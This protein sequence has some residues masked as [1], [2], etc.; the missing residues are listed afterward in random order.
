MKQLWRRFRRR[1]P[2]PAVPPPAVLPPVVLPPDSEQPFDEVQHWAP[3]LIGSVPVVAGLIALLVLL[4]L[5]IY[6]LRHRQLSDETSERAEACEPTDQHHA[7]QQRSSALGEEEGATQLRRRQPR[8]RDD[9]RVQVVQRDR[10]A[11]TRPDAVRPA[12]A[13]AVGAT[14]VEEEAEERRTKRARPQQRGQGEDAVV[15]LHRLRR[16]AAAT[17]LQ[18]AQRGRLA[19]Q[20]YDLAWRHA[21]RRTECRACSARAAA[22]APADAE[23]APPGTAAALA[24]GGRALSGGAAVLGGEGGRVALSA[25]RGL[26]GAAEAPPPREAEAE[27][28]ILRERST[29]PHRLAAEVAK[30]AEVEQEAA[31]RHVAEEGSSEACVPAASLV[32]A[33]AAEV[34]E[35]AAAAAAVAVAVA[36]AAPA[37]SVSMAQQQQALRED[38]SL[39]A[40]LGLP[41]RN[42]PA[43][44]AP[45]PTAAATAPPPRSR[46]ARRTGEEPPP[47]ALMR[48]GNG[49]AHVDPLADSPNWSEHLRLPPPVPAAAAPQAASTSTSTASLVPASP[50]P[51]M[52]PAW[53]EGNRWLRCFVP[54]PPATH[55]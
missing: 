50:S 26:E 43:A 42:E 33:E 36:V 6:L 39:R 23:E 53:V 14:A 28:P 13:Q 30:G 29:E 31:P 48:T 55:C 46:R 41:S 12:R 7:A 5:L 8:Q 4:A 20:R 40:A 15:A 54:Q 1:P 22:A 27:Q 38:E 25:A 47:V 3:T 18:A 44:E 10:L 9:A 19:R 16:A 11:P 52:M 49:N 32:E 35:A 34:A 24:A 51:A 21:R 37:A 2:P 45:Q 17:L